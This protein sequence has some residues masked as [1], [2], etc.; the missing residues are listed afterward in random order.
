M[1]N[2]LAFILILV[3]AVGGFFFYTSSGTP[4]NEAPPAVTT[5]ATPA[6]PTPAASEPAAVPATAPAPTPATAP[7]TTPTEPAKP[8]LL[9]V[10]A[11][12]IVALPSLDAETA[13]SVQEM[14]EKAKTMTEDEKLDMEKKATEMMT[15]TSA[16]APMATTA[17]ATTPTTTETASS[18]DASTTAPTATSVA[19]TP[20]PAKP[21]TR[22]GTFTEIDFV[23]KGSGKAIVYPETA[24]GPIVRLENFE[25]TR[26]PDLYVYLSKNID[27]K[28][29][30]ELGEYAS[31]GALKSSK[32]NQNYKLPAN[33][34]EYKSVVIW[35]QA[36]GV[37]FSSATL[38]P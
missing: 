32:G 26:G 18:T 25:V 30:K 36:F 16:T 33:F 6:P 31:L 14:I 15:K 3:I 9:K 21:V 38:K 23:H 8:E 5:P 19:A 4:V 20:A 29:R 11:E 10:P 7:T 37:L 12:D 34:T 27:I 1:E 2:F 28:T 13:K 24:D 22:E 17:P 35:C